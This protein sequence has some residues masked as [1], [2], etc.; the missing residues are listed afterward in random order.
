[1]NP[2]LPFDINCRVC[3]GLIQAKINLPLELISEMCQ[4]ESEKYVITVSLVCPYCNGIN[5]CEVAISREMARKI[6]STRE[7]ITR[8]ETTRYQRQIR[9]DQWD[10]PSSMPSACN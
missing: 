4:G 10:D 6:L 9:K 2:I 7:G 8:E 1:M 3:G 5:H